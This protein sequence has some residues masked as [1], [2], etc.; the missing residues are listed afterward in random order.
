MKKV[1]GVVGVLVLIVIGFFGYQYWNSTYNGVEA[2][3]LVTEGKKEASKNEDGSLY[4]VNG[5][6]YYTYEYE[7]KWVTK[8]GQTRNLGY[9]SEESANPKA[10][11]PGS[12]VKAKVAQKRVLTTP[13]P[14]S[15][16]ALPQ[17]VKAKLK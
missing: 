2:Y 5:K 10:L 4:K 15:K 7:L 16:Q 17:T 9:S 8:D 1:V 6:Q 13:Q 3:A 14:I 11:T 12:Y